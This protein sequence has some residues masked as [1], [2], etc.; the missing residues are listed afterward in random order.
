MWWLFYVCL[1]VDSM[2][3]KTVSVGSPLNLSCLAQ[4]Q[5]IKDTQWLFVKWMMLGVQKATQSR[6]EE[7]SEKASWVKQCLN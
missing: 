6:I 3:E 2:M 5:H 7:G 1:S 4:C